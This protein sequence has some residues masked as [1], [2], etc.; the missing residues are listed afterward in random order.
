ML[1]TQFNMDDALAVRYEEGVEDGI[2]R[3]RAEGV[4]EGSE[5]K[6]IQLI[7]RKLQKDLTPETIAEDLEETLENITQICNAIQYCESEDPKEIYQILK[8]RQQPAASA[9]KTS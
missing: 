8:T 4:A 9:E 2:E 3:G 7:Q 6:L 5:I 1:F